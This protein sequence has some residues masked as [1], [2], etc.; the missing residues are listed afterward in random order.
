VVPTV[1]QKR[2]V[3]PGRTDLVLAGIEVDL[4]VAQPFHVC[5][6]TRNLFGL[7]KKK[8]KKKKTK[9]SLFVEIEE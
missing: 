9:E 5:I 3:S 6:M 1:G 8:M 2:K 7:C 4:D